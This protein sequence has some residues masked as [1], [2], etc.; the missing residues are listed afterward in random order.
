MYSSLIKVDSS[1]RFPFQELPYTM[2]PLDETLNFL[3]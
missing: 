1:Q 3:T 2:R